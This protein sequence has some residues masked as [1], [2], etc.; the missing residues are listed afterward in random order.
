MSNRR[1][2]VV[3]LSDFRSKDGAAR[4]KFVTTFGDG[5]REF[6]FV[7]LQDHG[8][9]LELIRR[10]Y[11]D[12]AAFFALPEEAKRRYFSPELMGQRGYVPFG[13]EHAKNRSVGDLKEFWHVGRELPPGHRHLAAYGH[14]LWPAGCQPSRQTRSRSSRRS[15]RRRRRC[16]AHWPMT[17]E[18]APTRSAT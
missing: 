18:S 2:P 10:T 6:G 9:D 3:S 12:V 7:T 1:I 16:C 11:S 5:L 13:R 8:V 4:A 17:S 15:T 14:N